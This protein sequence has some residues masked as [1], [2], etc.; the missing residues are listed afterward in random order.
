MT[1]EQIIGLIVALLVMCV[2]LAGAILPGV[3]STPLVL[4]AAIAHKLYF[5]TTGAG[6]I[7][8]TMLVGLTTFA[9]LM[10][11]LATIYGAKKLGATWRG[12]VGAIVGGL[13]GLFFHLPGLLLGPFVGA[14]VFEKVSGRTWKDSGRAGVGATI[15]LLAGAL[16]K[17]TCCVAMMGLFTVNVIY[18]S[19]P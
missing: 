13:I 7:V 10:D 16:G 18:R 9:L 1:V 4:I 5:G 6:W 15:G 17:L 19:L 2:G 11:Y 3:P 8:M 12:A 14:F